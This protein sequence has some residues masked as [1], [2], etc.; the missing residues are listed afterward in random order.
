[1]KAL[2]LL[3]IFSLVFSSFTLMADEVSDA[4]NEGMAHYKKG[5]LSAAASQLDYAATL[6]RQQKAG[7]VTAVFPEPLA[8]WRAEKAESN[9]AG[10]MMMGGGIT[11]S[12]NYQ[13]GDASVEIELVMDSPMMQSIL[14]MFNNPS[15]IAMS[16]AKLIKV[17]GNKAMLKDED[18]DIE[19]QL[20]INNN[21][22]F[23]IRGYSVS[24]EQVKAYAEALNL[25][26]L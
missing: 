10:G 21:A 23:T 4:I 14:M 8:G 12:R 17:Q 11:A 22:L 7:K 6:I 13:K 9:S 20:V 15:M 24:V 16:G 5:D 1:M 2:K 3:S 26:K 19:I 18:G 25:D